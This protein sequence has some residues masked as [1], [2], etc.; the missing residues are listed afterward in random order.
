MRACTAPAAVPN[1]PVRMHAVV[2]V[3][4]SN[5]HSRF[6]PHGYTCMQ[7][8]LFFAHQGPCSLHLFP[9]RR[10]AGAPALRREQGEDGGR[11]AA[12]PDA[13]GEPPGGREPVQEAGLARQARHQLSCQR[14]GLQ[15]RCPGKTSGGDGLG[16]CKVSMLGYY[17]LSYCHVGESVIS[18]DENAME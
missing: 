4:N 6:C 2:F 3:C 17:L 1:N 12:A 14:R 16:L 18:S 13:G 11:A 9:L 5:P 15:Y 7:I 10:R 8:V